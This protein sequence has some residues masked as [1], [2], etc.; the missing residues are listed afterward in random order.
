M[1]KAYTKGA[2]L[3]AKKAAQA[4][5]RLAEV[6]K[7]QPNGRTRRKTGE[8]ETQAV[9]LTA[10]ARHMGKPASDAREM[11]LERLSDGAGMA[12]S[13]I[14]DPGTAESLWRH[15][16]SLTAAEARYHRSIGKS[17]HA[18]TAKIEMMQERFETRPDDQ[19][20]LRTQEERDRDAVHQWMR[21]QG[22]L[23]RIAPHHR[24]AIFDAYRYHVDLV[25][26]GEVL[27]AGRR[28]VRAMQVLSV[29]AE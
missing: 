15:Y 9:A 28:F 13:L 20:D 27:P 18:K 24:T 7:K 17:I 22:A 4:M 21:W 14:C 19:I 23:A 25:D 6:P 26:A 10:R 12:L 1:A 3:R 8:R 16:A 2:K 11:D 29:A 5:P